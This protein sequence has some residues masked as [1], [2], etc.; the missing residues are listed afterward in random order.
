MYYVYLI[1]NEKDEIYYGSTNNLRK[2]FKEHNRGEVKS[3]KG[4]KW[5]LVYYEAF[6]SEADAR[7]REKQLKHHGQ[8]LAQLK[9]RLKKSLPNKS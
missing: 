5:G 7:E 8:A 4:G 6:S 9:R 1:Q 2:R 3:T